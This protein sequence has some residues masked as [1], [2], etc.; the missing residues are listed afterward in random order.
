M[1][2]QGLLFQ[3]T[4]KINLRS[5]VYFIW[6]WR[7]SFTFSICTISYRLILIESFICVCVFE[8]A[9]AQRNTR[10]D[11]E[12]KKLLLIN[13]AMFI[14]C[15]VFMLYSVAIK[16]TESPVFVWDSAKT[17]ICLVASFGKKMW[18]LINNNYKYQTFQ[19]REWFGLPCITVHTCKRTLTLGC[20]S[21]CSV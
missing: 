21:F 18:A 5:L 17:D 8:K 7:W 16:Q 10:K 11:K 14:I 4:D 20:S 12:E 3:Q 1:E 19:P 13:L 15:M 9:E 2:D 6:S